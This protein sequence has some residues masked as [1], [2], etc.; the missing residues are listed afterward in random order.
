MED[1]R[2]I[3]DDNTDVNDG[4]DG[5]NDDND[6][7]DGVNDENNEVFMFQSLRVTCDGLE[8]V[9]TIIIEEWCVGDWKSDLSWKEGSPLLQTTMRRTSLSHGWNYVKAIV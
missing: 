8:T 2:E 6:E 3:A 7:D 1:T 5:E 9:D 4:A